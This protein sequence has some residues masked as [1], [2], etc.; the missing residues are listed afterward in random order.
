MKYNLFKLYVI[1][2]VYAYTLMNIG[3]ANREIV[4]YSQRVVTP[5][6]ISLDLGCV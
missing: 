2:L 4:S 5:M 6:C 1:I 3:L